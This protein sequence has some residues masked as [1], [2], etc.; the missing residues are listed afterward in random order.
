MQWAIARAAHGTQIRAVVHRHVV[1]FFGLFIE[2][3]YREVDYSLQ[4][5]RVTIFFADFLTPWSYVLI[6]SH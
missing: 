6:A 4:I 5:E 1:H 3:Q 2:I